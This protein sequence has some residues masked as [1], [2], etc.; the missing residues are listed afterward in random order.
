MRE[1]TNIEQ[2]WYTWASRGMEQIRGFQV[3]AASRALMDVSGT[4]FKT[5]NPYL[6]YD[7]PAGTNRLAA[8]IENS[9][10]CLAYIEAE[11]RRILLQKNFTGSDTSGRIGTYFV[12]LLD[13]LPPDFTARRAIELWK[14]PFWK[15][16]VPEFAT[17]E[18]FK[19]VGS[20]ELWQVSPYQLLQ[21]PLSVWDIKQDAMLTKLLPFVIEAYA[22]LQGQ[23]KLYIAAEDYRVA[24]LIWGLTQCLPLSMQHDLTF[25]T[26]EANLSEATTR[27]VGTCLPLSEVRREEINP[28]RLLPAYDYTVQHVTLNC[29]TGQHSSL[30]SRPWLAQEDA[31]LLAEYARY[32]ASRLLGEKDGQ[33]ELSRLLAIAKQQRV[34]TVKGLLFVYKFF[35]ARNL[36]ERDFSNMLE[37]TS[38]VVE[39]LNLDGV[40]EA[41]ISLAIGNEQWWSEEARPAITNLRKDPFERLLP[42]TLNNFACNVAR[43]VAEAILTRNQQALSITYDIL[44]TTAPASENANPWLVLLAAFSSYNPLEHCNWGVR[45]ELLKQWSYGENRISDEQIVPWLVIS[46][47]ELE[48]FLSLPLPEHWQLQAIKL[49]LSRTDLPLRSE[50]VEVIE[51]PRYQQVLV[52]ALKQMYE[53]PRQ[54]DPQVV[55]DFFKT[56]VTYGSELRFDALDIFLSNQNIDVDKVKWMLKLAC[57]NEA[58]KLYVF[59]IHFNFLLICNTDT[60]SLLPVVKEMIKLYLRQL[61]AYKL[62]QA[63]T[64]HILA[65]IIQ[66]RDMLTQELSKQAD[67]WYNAGRAI[68]F[69]QNEILPPNFDTPSLEILG[70]AA[71]QFRTRGG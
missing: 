33:V 8:S 34:S 26:Y 6:G 41:I 58:E 62:L 46:W 37:I 70:K 30:Q 12:H 22:G 45:S 19:D 56:L 23:Q 68:C 35:A 55:I 36:T 31:Q 18:D 32:A 64:R 28:A 57:S 63:N 65:A 54:G 39:Y 50:M 42:S 13:A 21:G 52:T 60:M 44:Q 67:L 7:L 51:Q 4:T 5:I 43:K 61:T 1:P 10:F 53:D 20:Y 47:E 2:L 15:T 27:I 17:P 24:S 25:S 69:G 11:G 9:P 16:M 59:K 3:Y 29:Y 38:M 71:L 49:L 14:S 48:S 66:Q 40:Q